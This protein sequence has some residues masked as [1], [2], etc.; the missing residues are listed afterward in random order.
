VHETASYH[1]LSF[2]L[3][4]PKASNCPSLYFIIYVR[5]HKI[6]HFLQAKLIMR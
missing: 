2:K 3:D 4:V 5:T 1:V 6:K